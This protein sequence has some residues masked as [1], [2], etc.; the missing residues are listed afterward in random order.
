MKG[1]GLIETIYSVGIL[2][3][4]LTGVVILILMVV[5]S[6]KTQFDRGKATELGSMVMEETVNSSKNDGA[7][8]WTLSNVTNQTKAGFTGYTYSIGFT[9]IANNPTYPNCGNAGIN[10]CAEVV[11]RVDWPGKNPQTITF[12]RFFSKNGN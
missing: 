10:D 1:Q 12:N 8:F 11:V 6:K 2:G 3:L 7:N 5:A 4:M 9:N